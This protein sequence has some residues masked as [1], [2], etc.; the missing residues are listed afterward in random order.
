MPFPLNGT[1]FCNSICVLTKVFMLESVLGVPL[2][3]PLLVN[4]KVLT[5]LFILVLPTP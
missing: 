2:S 3:K 5:Y 4:S 1:W